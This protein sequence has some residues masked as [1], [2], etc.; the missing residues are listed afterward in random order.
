[1]LFIISADPNLSNSSCH[2]WKHKSVFLQILWHSSVP[3][4][5]S[6]LYLFSSN[7]YFGQRNQLK[8]HSFRFSS[9]Q[10]KLHQIPLSMLIWQVNSCSNFAL[11]VVI[12]THSSSVNFNLI[13]FLLRQKDPMKI[14]VLILLSALVKICQ[15]PQVI[16]QTKSPFFANFCFT[17]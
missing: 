8:S 6:F 5:I 15:I 2:F 17:L 1:M 16:F 10:V 7:I 14:P 4:N 11:F 12:L 9:A 3:S 13:H